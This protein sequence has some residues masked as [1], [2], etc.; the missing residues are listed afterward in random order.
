[1]RKKVKS[2]GEGSGTGWRDGKCAK[3]LA[4]VERQL[5]TVPRQKSSELINVQLER[6]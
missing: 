1:M 2:L 6:S 4:K 3:W 5:K